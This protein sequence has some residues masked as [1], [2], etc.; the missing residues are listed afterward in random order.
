[1]VTSNAP[2]WPADSTTP[3]ILH[4]AQDL[5]RYG[6]DVELLAPHAAG[7]K[8]HEVLDGIVI[9]RF[10]Y[11]RPT[12]YQRL[13]YGGG[14]L[15]NARASIGTAAQIPLFV[16][17][18]IAA[19]ARQL[20]SNEYDVVQSHW[21]VPQGLTTSLVA[22]RYGVPHLATIHGSDVLG[23]HWADRLK[24][25]ALES[26]DAVSV[27]SEA[28]QSAVEAIAPGQ[29][30]V[31]RIPMGISLPS[32]DERQVE[33]INT[34]HRDG[35][36]PLLVFV[37][38][39]VG[40]K[41][42]S[43]LLQAVQEL[44]QTYPKVRCLVAGSG[45]QSDALQ[46]EAAQRGLEERVR[47]L[48]WVQPAEVPALYAA[49][50]VIVCPSRVET[51]GT[52]EGQGLAILEGMASGKPVVATRVGGIPDSIR[53]GIDGL[54]V[55][56]RDPSAIAHAVSRLLS[57]PDVARELGASAAQRAQTLFS[58]DTSARRFDELLSTLINPDESARSD[59]QEAPRK[60]PTIR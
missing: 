38:R 49:A 25:R 2:R 33:T 45:P 10:R 23:L 16:G 29:P 17:A 46:A 27:N 40:W 47:F 31:V 8:Q 32:V 59:R 18:Q 14:A 12:R 58:R 13:A 19:V 24:K 48:G 4:L 7:A 55:P 57:D 53:D 44:A 5:D 9:R 28:T 37:G 54:L 52:T 41:G 50:D 11:L 56:E 6:W 51:D 30:N 39:L 34:T 35:T 20:R 22:H 1:M 42:V 36:G 60:R 3:F 26:A 43:D 15:F 21:V